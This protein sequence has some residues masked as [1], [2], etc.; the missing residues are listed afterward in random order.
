MKNKQ[1]IIKGRGMESGIIGLALGILFFI[2]MILGIMELEWSIIIVG[3]IGAAMML[4]IGIYGLLPKVLVID[5]NMIQYFV[6]KEKKF[7]THWTDITEINSSSIRTTKSYTRFVDIKAKDD[8]LSISDDS[9][10][11]FTTLKRIF[12]ILEDIA[13]QYPNVTFKDEKGWLRKRNKP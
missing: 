5:K 11:G 7:E 9:E 2:I 6:N 12:R 1:V 3:A 10:F 4:W 8:S 13:E